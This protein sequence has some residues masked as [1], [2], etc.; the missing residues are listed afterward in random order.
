MQI[1]VKTLTE[2]PSPSMSKRR[3]PLK[4]SSR[5][6][7]TK[8]NSPDQQ[9]LIFAG[10]QLEDGRTLSDYNITKEATLHLVASPQGRSYRPSQR[11][12]ASTTAT[13]RSAASATLDFLLVRATAARRSADVRTSSD[14]RRSSSKSCFCVAVRF[15]LGVGSEGFPLRLIIQVRRNRKGNAPP[16][17]LQIYL[18]ITIPVWPSGITHPC[19]CDE[20]TR[21]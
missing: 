3:T 4:E 19:A 10:K 8:R 20:T 12:P 2:R 1:F 11:S 13:R 7:R 17:F 16:P 5:R 15:L 18:S 21:F 14:R 6:F 9:R